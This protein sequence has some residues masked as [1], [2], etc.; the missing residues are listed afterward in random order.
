MNRLWEILLGLDRGFLSR[1]GELS[2][3]FH[4]TWPFADI[5]GNGLWNLMLVVAAITLVVWVYNR[6]GKSQRWRLILGGGRLLVLLLLIALLNRP[7]LTLTRARVEPSILAVMV[8]DSVSMR[9]ADLQD[10]AGQRQSR[11]EAALSLLTGRDAALLKSLDETHDLRFF[12]FDRDAVRIEGEDPLA[13]LTALEPTGPSTAVAEAVRSALSDLQ[14]QNLAGILLLTDGRDAPARPDAAAL[15]AVKQAGVR[16][17]PVPIGGEQEPR[18][19]EVQSVVAQDVAFAGDIVNIVAVVRAA[20]I[21]GNQPVRLAL[22]DQDGNAVMNPDGQPVTAS[23]DIAG[24]VP[25][26]VELHLETVTP[27][28]LQLVVEAEPDPSEIDADD[29]RRPVHIEV[30]DAKIAVLYVEGY[31]RW[32]YKHL[33]NHVVRDS[34]INASVLLTSADPTFAQEGDTPIQRFPV[35]IDEL[36]DYDV[37]LLGD[38]SPQQFSDGQLQLIE[39]FVGD[40]GGGFGMMAGPRDSPWAWQGTPIERLLPVEVVAP[41]EMLLGEGGAIAEGFRP[42][43]TDAG[44][45]SGIFRFERE[46]EANEEYLRSGIQPLF[47]FADGLIAKPGVGEVLASH[48][49]T[50]A[51][52]GRPAP[53]VVTGRYGAGR[54]LFSA[55]DETWRWRYYTGEH[56]FDTYWV[57]QLRFLARG[58]KLGQRRLALAVQRPT[59]ELGQQVQVELRLLDP[60]LSRQLPDRL[61]LEVRNEQGQPVSTAS[62]IRRGEGAEADRYTA[63]FPAGRIGNFVVALPPMA[64]GEQEL[65]APVTVQVPQLE[66]DRPIVDRPSLQR[67]A[68]DTGGQLVAISEAGTLPSV[69]TSVE[70]RIP[71]VS[72]QALWDA[73]LAL[74]L[75]ALLITMEWVGRKAAGLI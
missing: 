12:R 65:T 32:E 47:W 41:P 44:R 30:M 34:T 67:L 46:R 48:P 66:L 10:S 7:A 42:L 26:E 52:D 3:R 31:P 75:F 20:G 23:A 8:D 55:L 4:P 35:S 24:G 22:K 5:L 59:Y 70:K 37:V 74:A 58:R 25:T 38:V 36:L 18:N 61:E 50:S 62:L 29:N 40:K 16:L 54:T 71:I 6:E 13:A 9:V 49:E 2:L 33:K 43:L 14:G 60:A 27:G 15:A 56:V 57:Q 68:D 72:D 51:P 73:P 11:L 63:S 17:F 53:L 21:E 64:G 19:V 39:E 28:T 1:D 69:I 45:Q